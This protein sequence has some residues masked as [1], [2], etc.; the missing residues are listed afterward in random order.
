[1]AIPVTSMPDTAFI[2]RYANAM[3]ELQERDILE[4]R[5]AA[6][7]VRARMER[8]SKHPLMKLRGSVPESNFYL[9]V[10]NMY[11]ICG[12]CPNFIGRDAD[13]NYC[14]ESP[15]SN[16]VFRVSRNGTSML[17]ATL[18]EDDAGLTTKASLGVGYNGL[19]FGFALKDGSPGSGKGTELT[20]SIK[21]ESSGFSLTSDGEISVGGVFPIDSLD[22]RSARNHDSAGSGL[23]P[24]VGVK[25]EINYDDS[26]SLDVG[27]ARFVG[28]TGTSVDGSIVATAGTEAGVYA[29]ADLS[30]AGIG[31]DLTTL[32]MGA[33]AAGMQL[34]SFGGK[35]FVIVGAAEG[36]LNNSL[37]AGAEIKY[38]GEEKK[39]TLKTGPLKWKGRFKVMDMDEILVRMGLTY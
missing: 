27:Y 16:K 25:G 3:K 24:N 28:I 18:K 10:A 13:G 36:R 5:Q 34:V 30:G 19:E 14:F 38:G 37:S 32:S 4:M 21:H 29:K 6:E 1:M 31:A 39:I 20:S 7:A 2:T 11:A 8:L 35:T 12:E 15:D 9:I 22:K 26:R 17:Y 23:H 33:E